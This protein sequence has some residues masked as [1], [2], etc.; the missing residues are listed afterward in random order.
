MVEVFENNRRVTILVSDNESIQTCQVH[1]SL[2]KD[3]LNLENELC[4]CKAKQFVISCENIKNMID[5]KL[6]I[7]FFMLWEK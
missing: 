6:D 4:P 3:V 5:K 7:A 2:V 1:T